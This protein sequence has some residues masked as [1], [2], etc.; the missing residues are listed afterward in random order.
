MVLR[1]DA[2]RSAV[3]VLTVVALGGFL[4][5]LEPDDD[6]APVDETAVLSSSR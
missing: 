6:V 3:A 2:A 5:V 1:S 4:A